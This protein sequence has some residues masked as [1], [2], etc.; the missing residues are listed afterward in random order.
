MHIIAVSGS[1]R[2]RSA[3]P[4]ATRRYGGGFK[5]VLLSVV[6]GLAGSGGAFGAA[7]LG[8]P[9]NYT[10][11]I[12]GLD[13]GDVLTLVA[14][15]YAQGLRIHDLHGSAEHPIVI[16]GPSG[17]EPAVVLGRPQ[18]NI[19]SIKNASHVIVRNLEIDGR[20]AFV[21]GVK[22]EGHADFAHHITLEN[23]FIHS[24]A[25]HQ[26]SVGIST[27]CPAWDWVVRGNRI[28]G[29][30]TGMY[31][32]DSDGSD[33]F[34]GGIIEDNLVMNTI[35]YNLQ[36]KHQAPR[37]ALAGM[38]KEP[39][40]TVIRGNRFVKAAGSSGGAAA[41]PNVLVGHLPPHGPGKDDQYAI[42]RNL[43]FQNPGE[44][45][46]QGEGNLAL[47]ANLF[48]NSHAIE[49]PAVAIQPHNDIPRRIRVFFNTVVHPWAGIRVL[50]R[51]DRW[52]DDQQL[53]GNA[54][55]AE[56]PLQGGIQSHNLTDGYTAVAEYLT[57][58]VPSLG[59]MDLSPRVEKLS[60]EAIEL[61]Q[62]SWLPE[63]DRDFTGLVRSGRV[64]G[65]H[66]GGR[67]AQPFQPSAA[68]GATPAS[69]RQRPSRIPCCSQLDQPWER[70]ALARRPHR[71]ARQPATPTLARDNSSISL[72][73]SLSTQD[74]V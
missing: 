11:L 35:G 71:T 4:A 33:P 67:H 66:E 1:T 41:R 7:Y 31:F 25:R 28:E 51:P 21:D 23:L 44:A 30:G 48:F 14:G 29:A 22:A 50:R 49:V 46:F 3:M 55:F 6:L 64:R 57:R 27:K 56:T 10:E 43:F 39:R 34:I 20:N 9:E 12:A 26:Q 17:G 62:F 18:H 24:L 2:R 69:G 32:G 58:P 63:H 42:Y 40:V 5:S 73:S 65:A 36:V 59:D 16:E 47:Y 8:T 19:V 70:P 15:R 45:L 61:S 38:P 53:I 60:G 52:V 37:P 54:V 68:P 13:P 74:H 72:R